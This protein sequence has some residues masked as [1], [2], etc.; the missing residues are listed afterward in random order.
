MEDEKAIGLF[1]PEDAEKIRKKR[2]QIYPDGMYP[3]LAA[4]D[5]I[6][7]AGPDAINK[8]HPLVRAL[9]SMNR[10]QRRAFSSEL[11]KLNRTKK[12]GLRSA[13]EAAQRRGWRGVVP[14]GAAEM[15]REAERIAGTGP[16]AR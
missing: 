1:D 4:G 12:P 8:D 14:M 10:G 11:R 13:W 3:N 2:E 7:K 15:A 6:T 9:L 5:A 16:D